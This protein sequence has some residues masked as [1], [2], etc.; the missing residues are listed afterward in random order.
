VDHNVHNKICWYQQG[1]TSLIL[2]GPLIEQLDL[3]QS[4]K[5]TTG[6]SH[7]TV[8]TL[9]GANTCTCIIGG[10]NP[11]GNNKPDSDMV[12]QQ[13]RC[14]FIT[15]QRDMTC[16]WKHFREDIISQLKKWWANNNHLIVCLDANEDI[17]MKSLGK[18]LRIDNGLSKK[19]VVGEFT[20]KKVGPKFFRGSKPIDSIWATSNMEISNTCIMPVGYGIGNHRMCIV[21]IVQSSLIGKGPFCIQR[22]VSRCLNTKSAGGGAAKYIATLELSLARHRLIEKLGQA[23]EQNQSKRDF[24]Q[25]IN[26]LD[27][28]SKELMKNVKKTCWPAGSCS[29][30]R[31]HCGSGAPLYTDHSFNII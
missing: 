10:Y 30:L 16:P 5:D 24:Q 7:W 29:V 20:G 14:F 1:G 23:H 11:C 22:L 12:Y 17:Y 31:R 25:L 6:L 13:H 15:Q 18:A 19:E 21:N 27:C 8:M 9:Q 2:F 4:G 3:D 28:K 26:K